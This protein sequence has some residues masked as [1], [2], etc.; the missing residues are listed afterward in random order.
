MNTVEYHTIDIG[1]IDTIRPLWAQLNQHHHSQA[2]VFRDHY[3]GM[4]FEQRKAHF[5]KIA[6]Q[7]IIRIELATAIPGKKAVGYCVSSLSA[8]KT[9]EIESIFVE[10]QFRGRGIGSELLTRALAWLGTEGS[11]RNRVSVGNGNEEA[12]GFYR[13]FGF[14]PRMTVF[15]QV[16]RERTERD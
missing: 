10:E 11:V 5:Q 4:T 8:E 2:N 9:G 1:E 6:G 3:E 15:E 14:F 16:H 13:K 12:F 7:G